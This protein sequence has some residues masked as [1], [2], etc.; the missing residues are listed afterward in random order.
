MLWMKAGQV[1]FWRDDP[2][3]DQILDGFIKQCTHDVQREEMLSQKR[4]IRRGLSTLYDRI[5]K[6]ELINYF[7]VAKDDLEDILKIFVRVNSGATILSKTDLLFSTI[8]AT[9]NDGREQI[10]NLIKEINGKG[11]GFKFGNEYLMRCCL[12]LSDGPVVFK[13]N[14]FKSDNV[15]KIRDEWPR[16]AD[17]VKKTVDLLVEFGFSGSVLTSEIS[18][19]IIAYYIH[20]GGGLDK[21]SKKGIQKYLIHALLNGIYNSSQDALI[22]AL[23]NGMREETIMPAGVKTYR[24]RSGQFS[25]DEM[26]KISLPQQKSLEVTEADIERFLQ[27]TKGASSFFVLSLLYPQLRFNEVVFHQDHMH[28]AAGFNKANFEGVG[29]PPEQWQEWLDCRDSV[30][31]LQLMKDR[32]NESKNAT[33][34]KAWVDGMV[35]SEQVAFFNDNYFPANE[36]LEFGN[37]MQFFKLR[38]EILRTELR[39]VLALTNVQAVVVIPE[40]G[41]Q[42]EESDI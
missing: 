14:S 2:E 23:R 6:E 28:P 16:V 36:S 37:F 41:D 15:Q 12:V 34:L 22:A 42:T 39:Q 35:A 7:E 4:L 33:P 27:I 25:F 13:V 40:W 19:I 32:Q 18:T 31:N 8:V 30:P 38:K 26:L 9:W 10:E 29:L 1:L 3:F 17:A 11:D 20:K 21:K 24:G 5:R